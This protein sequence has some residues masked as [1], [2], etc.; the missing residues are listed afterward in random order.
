MAP[1]GIPRLQETGLDLRVLLFTAGLTILTGL[2]VAFAPIVT[3]GKIDLSSAL[4]SGGRSGTD[5]RKQRSFRNALAVAAITIT[6]VLAFSSGLV[7]R[8]LVG[9]KN[10]IPAFV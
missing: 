2:L 9:T 10:S 5:T 8:R 4:N 3:S 7:L 1:Q 6:L